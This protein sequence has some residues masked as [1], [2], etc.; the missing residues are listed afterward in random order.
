MK[1]LAAKSHML[2]GTFLTFT[3]ASGVAAHDVESEY[4][5]AC[6]AEYHIFN[7]IGGPIKK[8]KVTVMPGFKFLAEHMDVPMDIPSNKNYRIPTIIRF[9]DG[10][11]SGGQITVGVRAGRFSYQFNQIDEAVDDETFERSELGVTCSLI[12]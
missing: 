2:L 4:G 10:Q 1:K 3:I 6:V 12:L 8:R 5:V 7:S 9:A 11:G